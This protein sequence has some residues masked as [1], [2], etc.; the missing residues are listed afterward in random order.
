MPKP[1]CLN[2]RSL[3]GHQF[4]IRHEESYR[5]ERP[6]FRREVE[7]WLQIIPCEHGHIYP[8][9]GN[10]LARSAARPGS[11]NERVKSLPFATVH[12][13]GSDGANVLFDV[14]YF[15]QVAEIVHPKRR[16]PK[17]VLTPEHLQKMQTAHAKFLESHPDWKPGQSVSQISPLN[18]L[19]RART[20]LDVPKAQEG[21]AS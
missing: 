4:K 12:Q 11:I 15:D 13:D 5:A 21:G 9:G 14:R 20:H 10:L 1:T 3:F 2:L 16:P 17:R 6:E 18:G 8:H 7:P 19:E